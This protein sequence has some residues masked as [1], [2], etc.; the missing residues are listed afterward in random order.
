MLRRQSLLLLGVSMGYA[1]PRV[2]AYRETHLQ[3]TR[4]V[5]LACLV[6]AH[7]NGFG[8]SRVDQSRVAARALVH[9]RRCLLLRAGCIA[10]WLHRVSCLQLMAMTT[11]P[12]FEF[13]D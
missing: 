7:W 10:R 13:V 3:S 1:N 11:T 12:E 5:G 2:D 8:C 6:V 4:S 9:L